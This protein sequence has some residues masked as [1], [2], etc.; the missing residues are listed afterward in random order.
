[1][2]DS[3]IARLSQLHMGGNLPDLSLIETSGQSGNSEAFQE[4]G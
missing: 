4:S 1:M 3:I 2:W